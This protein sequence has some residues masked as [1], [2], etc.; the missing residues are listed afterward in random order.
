MVAVL[1]DSFCFAVMF[2]P[3]GH[4]KRIY[5]F[6]PSAV[7]ELDMCERD[8]VNLLLLSL[9]CLGKMFGVKPTSDQKLTESL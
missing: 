3:F 5:S 6:P 7:T 9:K 4:K 2:L 1:R 8:A